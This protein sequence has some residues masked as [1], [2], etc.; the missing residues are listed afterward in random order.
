MELVISQV[1]KTYANVTAIN[2]LS[3]SVSQGEIFALLGPNGAG[4]SPIIRMITG[5]TQP[6]SGNISLNI[7]GEVFDA[8]QNVF[9]RCALLAT[10]YIIGTHGIG[11]FMD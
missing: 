9:G 5:F 1:S 7:D 2:K 3:F 4:K 8:G 10:T 6:D 11:V